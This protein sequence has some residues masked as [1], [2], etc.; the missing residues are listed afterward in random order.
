MAVSML[1]RHYASPLTI[2]T[3]SLSHEFL[4]RVLLALLTVGFVAIVRKDEDR[5]LWRRTS[6]NPTSDALL[7]ALCAIATI[8]TCLH[9][10]SWTVL[11][12][13]WSVWRRFIIV[14]I[15]ILSWKSL[16]LDCDIGTGNSHVQA[17]LALL[18]AALLVYV[19][20]LWVIVFVYT[21]NEY[22]GAWEHHR[23]LPIRMLELFSSFVLA[24]V[25]GM[26]VGFSPADSSRTVIIVVL[27]TTLL[28]SHYLVP[29]IAK[30]R[31]GS[32]WYSWIRDNRLDYLTAAAYMSGWVR[33]LRPVVVSGALRHVQRFNRPLNLLAVGIECATAVCLVNKPLF[34]VVVASVCV[35]HV[36][37]FLLS[38]ICFW[39]NVVT[40]LIFG[41]TVLDLSADYNVFSPLC[42]M[43]VLTLF[44]LFPLRRV[45]WAPHKL[46]WWDS[47]F[48]ATVQWEVVGLSG[49]KYGLYNDW[50]CPH[51]RLFGRVYG[52]CLTTDLFVHYH[53]G[54]VRALEVR[55]L[56]VDSNGDRAIIDNIKD[57]FGTCYY[58]CDE[59]RYH[60]HY[61]KQFLECLNGGAR[62]QLFSGWFRWLKAPGSQWYYWGRSARFTG[63]EKIVRLDVVY[64][65]DFYDGSRFTCVSER[66]IST[67]EIDLI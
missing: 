3:A 26:H 18:I 46:A 66:I 57:A 56:L 55:N 62:K 36:S 42:V 22:L 21:G 35:F 24:T 59:K 29:G 49:I 28:V 10:G 37:V 39:E 52:Y 54:I 19:H 16:T 4:S 63:Q 40:L 44:V 31:L 5:L 64:R 50:L 17:R 30:L 6:L 8:A 41:V 1:A 15:A 53:L 12:P 43:A 27:L 65:E 2:A 11:G 13:S 38:G 9:V 20:P 14:L 45:A 47:P 58:D 61:M 23:F 67:T 48:V 7:F 34:V 33:F 32:R 51:E 25:V 60:D